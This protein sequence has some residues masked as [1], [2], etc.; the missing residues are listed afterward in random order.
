MST[1]LIILIAVAWYAVGV[2]NTVKWI[3]DT[4]GHTDADRVFAIFFGL[5]LG[6]FGPVMWLFR[7]TSK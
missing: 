2:Y 5:Y 6:I 3:I 4:H 7:I 1:L